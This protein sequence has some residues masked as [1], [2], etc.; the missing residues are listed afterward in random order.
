MKRKTVKGSFTIEMTYLMGIFAFVF[1]TV[2]YT[3]FYFHD[4]AVLNSA[5]YECAVVGSM[6]ARK[7]DFEK[8]ELEVLLR[9]RVNG[10]CLFLTVSAE[11][12]TLDEKRVLVE[13]LGSKGPAKVAIRQEAAITYGE[14]TLRKHY[15]WKKRL[16]SP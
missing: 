5:A 15:I 16:Q 7:K 9:E 2:I 3:I 12:V 4:K 10:R 13:L 1:I 11:K 6:K 14:D 8:E